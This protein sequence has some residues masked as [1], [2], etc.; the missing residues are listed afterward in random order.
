M[1]RVLI[2]LLWS[3]WIRILCAGELTIVTINVWSGLIYEGTFKM[4]EYESK[5]IRG[6]RYAILV[7]QLRT[8]DPDVI[9][10]QEANKLPHYASRL[11]RDLKMDRIY[12]VG[13]GGMKMGC[14][15]IPTNLKEGDAILAKPECRLKRVRAVRLSGKGIISDVVSFHFSESNQAIVGQIVTEDGPVYI[16]NVH[17][18]AGLGKDIHWSRR[19]DF[20]MDSGGYS[21]TDRRDAVH[22]IYKFENCWIGSRKHYPWMHPLYS[23]AILMHLRISLRFAG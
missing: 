7:N 5:D 18:H 14:L 17:A 16:I 23:W 13:L 21:S 10:L 4:G 6:K 12:S 9:A 20:W 2:L 22:Y 8:L 3:G 19:M 1:R 15:G 11:A